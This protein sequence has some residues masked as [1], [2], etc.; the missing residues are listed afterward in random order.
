MKLHINNF[1]PTTE[2][3]V[4]GKRLYTGVVRSSPPDT[5]Q[6]VI[7]KSKDS[8]PQPNKEAVFIAPKSLPVN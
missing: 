8:N 4:A 5:V 2:P 7:L 6:H 3:A 1:A